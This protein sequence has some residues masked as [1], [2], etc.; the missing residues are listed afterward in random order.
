MN[1]KLWS[2]SKAKNLISFD[3]CIRRTK[4]HEDCS[5]WR[6]RE[7]LF[8]TVTW[9][10]YTET[11]TTKHL[12]RSLKKLLA[13]SFIWKLCFWNEKQFRRTIILIPF[14]ITRNFRVESF[15]NL[16]KRFS[17]GPVKSPN[18]SDL[19]KSNKLCF[20]TSKSLSD[21]VRALELQRGLE[22]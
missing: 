14:R 9:S 11:L 19:E 5:F 13:F 20:S 15:S 7:S 12:L 1:H 2:I 22:L 8:V 10:A 18:F 6:S 3:F 4:L 17:N 16:F 21:T